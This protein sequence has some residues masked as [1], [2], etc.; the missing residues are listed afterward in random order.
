MSV[1]E[2]TRGRRGRWPGGVS[3]FHKTDLGAEVKFLELSLGG[4]AGSL[5]RVGGLDLIIIVIYKQPSTSRYANRNFFD[6]FTETLVELL[7]THSEAEFLILGDFNARI[8]GENI[9]LRG[10][11]EENELRGPT[12]MSKDRVL[13]AEGRELLAFC[14]AFDFEILNGKYGRDRKGELSFINANGGSVIDYAICSQKVI[15]FIKDFWVDSRIESHHFPIVVQ[16][17]GDRRTANQ[18][19]TE[20]NIGIGTHI[21]RYRWKEELEPQF[22]INLERA[23]QTNKTENIDHITG[24]MLKAASMMKQ[25]SGK[26]KRGEGWYDG[27]C[28]EKKKMA[29][30]ALRKFRVEEGEEERRRFVECRQRYK[31]VTRGKKLAWETKI[32]SEFRQVAERGDEGELWRAIKRFRGRASGEVGISPRNWLAHFEMV[33]GGGVWDAGRITVERELTLLTIPQLDDAITRS[34]INKA[35]NS[36]KNNKAPGY[37]GLP[38]EIFK[39]AIKLDM[40]SEILENIFNHLFNNG[41]Y[42]ECWSTAVIHPIYKGKGSTNMPDNYRGVA[43]LP[44][45]GKIYCKILYDRMKDWGEKFG[46][47]SKFQAGFRSGYS[48]SDNVFILD[49]LRQKEMKRRGGKLHCAFVDFKRAFDS[50]QREALWLK[51]RRKGLSDKMLKAIQGIYEKVEFCVKYDMNRVSESITSRRGVRQGCILSPLLFNLF[52]D[53][54][55]EVMREEGGEVNA[56]QVENIPVPALLYADDLILCSKSVEGLQKKLDKLKTYCDS[57]GLEVN[58]NKTK[59][60]TF[61]NGSVYSRREEWTYSGQRLENVKSFIYLGVTLSMN[62]QWTKHIDMT[63]HKARIKLAELMRIRSRIPDFPV[64][65]LEKMYYALVRSS[66]SYG[67][68]IWGWERTVVI[69]Q[70]QTTFLKQILGVARGTSNSGVLKEFG[71]YNEEIEVKIRAVKY[72]LRIMQGDQTLIKAAC[73]REQRREGGVRMWADKL[74]RG[75]QGIGMGWVREKQ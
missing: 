75:L 71:A 15:T 7:E 27:E 57:W 33:F 54:I 23:L 52:I 58:S 67:A 24:H 11:E 49:H 66:M 51:L 55:T 16:L 12:R 13:N 45:M 14:D 44:C 6:D 47:I 1:G 65:T 35:I 18:N 9:S 38:G 29:E 34:E 36:L 28:K 4:A 43:L 61:K 2:E 26:R 70:I 56:P 41:R 31:S 30:R 73:Y 3:V 37:D 64:A 39:A 17:Q 53:D 5:L 62:G 68:E 32:A 72:W 8:G 69:N 50:V 19:L 10:S 60:M 20:E 40:F 25:H 74:R 46:K 48:T 21:Q 63:K 42:P 59:T 22:L